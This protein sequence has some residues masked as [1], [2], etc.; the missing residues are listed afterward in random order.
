MNRLLGRTNIARGLFRRAIPKNLDQPQKFMDAYMAMEH[1]I[2]NADTI[3][4]MLLR[5]STKNR[6]LTAQWQA[7]AR[8]QAAA[9]AAKP[10]RPA[11]VHRYL[12]TLETYS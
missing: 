6:T 3:T 9:E 2:G 1:E 8:A 5:I 11:K 7:E 10:Q 4:D 12:V